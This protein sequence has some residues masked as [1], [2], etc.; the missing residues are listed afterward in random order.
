MAEKGLTFPPPSR[1]SY[2]SHSLRLSTYPGRVSP[3]PLNPYVGASYSAAAVSGGD[4][5]APLLVGDAIT[6]APFVPSLDIGDDPL[7]P[8]RPIQ[9]PGQPFDVSRYICMVPPFSELEIEVYFAHFE[10]VAIMLQWPV[11][12]WT[13][14][15]QTV[16]SGEAQAVY[17]ALSIQQS[18]DYN[19]VKTS[20][21]RAYE[22]VPEAYR[23][24][25][26]NL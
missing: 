25:F 14:L 3:A 1:S 8:V 13:L 26:R 15:L 5:D 24:K 22:L 16:L 2:P 20:V 10:R 12:V 9:P 17:S 4:S 23:Q 6:N 7:A 19:V 11:E 18:F 21:L